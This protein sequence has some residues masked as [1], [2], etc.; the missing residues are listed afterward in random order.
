MTSSSYMRVNVCRKRRRGMIYLSMRIYEQ[1]VDGDGTRLQGARR[2][3]P[4]THSGPAA[5]RGGLRL[6]HPRE[7]AHLAAE[8]LP[9]PRV[10]ATFRP[11]RHAQGGAVGALPLGRVV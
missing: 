6:S 4:V 1:A 3:D 10:S 11:G 9:T 5:H 7:P 2:Y 8:G